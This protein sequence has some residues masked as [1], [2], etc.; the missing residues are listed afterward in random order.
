MDFGKGRPVDL[1]AN[2][3]LNS[4]SRL[5]DISKWLDIL[6]FNQRY[7]SDSIRVRQASE[8]N[9][10]I[11]FAKSAR[12]NQKSRCDHKEGEKMPTE[13]FWL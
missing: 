6:A 2:P 4:E 7:D 10:F 1:L 8:I 9:L 5:V 12:H 11:G 3:V 13:H